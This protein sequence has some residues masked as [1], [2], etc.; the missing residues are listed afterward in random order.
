[1]LTKLHLTSS[2]TKNSELNGW[3]RSIMVLPMLPEEDIL[4]VYRLLSEVILQNTNDH[5]INNLQRL[6]SYIKREWI[7]KN[8]LSISYSI[9][10]TN[11]CFEVYHRG[12]KSLI[13]VKKPNPYG[14]LWNVSKDAVK[15]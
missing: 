1:M 8:D 10:I 12:L 6:K 5:E 11:N 3:I 4:P 7:N 2:Y 14:H 9:Q 13:R 15:I